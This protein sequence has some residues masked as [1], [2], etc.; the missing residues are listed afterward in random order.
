MCMTQTNG[1][2]RLVIFAPHFA[3][4]LGWSRSQQQRRQVPKFVVD[5]SGYSC[6]QELVKTV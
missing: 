5:F 1:S 4:F 2:A 3:Q 6:K